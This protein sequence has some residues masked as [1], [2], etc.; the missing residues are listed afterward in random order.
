MGVDF[1][2]IP[3]DPGSG[4]T[5]ARSP[6]DGGTSSG[7]RDLRKRVL[8]PKSPALVTY[9]LAE[10]VSKAQFWMSHCVR[11]QCW[12]YVQFMGIEFYD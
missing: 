12:V 6:G 4:K 3:K 11:L 5:R 10:Q 9:F 2:I 1:I 7:G 8:D